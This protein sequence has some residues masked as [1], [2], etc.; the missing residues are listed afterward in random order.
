MLELQRGK[1]L[2]ASE[3]MENVIKGGSKMEKWSTAAIQRTFFSVM[4]R[5]RS[6]GPIAHPAI[7]A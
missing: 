3:Y 6:V 1:M 7:D 2:L 4:T 5:L